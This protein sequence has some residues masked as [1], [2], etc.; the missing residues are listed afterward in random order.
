MKITKKITAIFCI[1]AILLILNH[2]IPVL[3]AS[4]DYVVKEL[5]FVNYLN[6]GAETVVADPTGK[7]LLFFGRND[8]VY[9]YNLEH[10]I[11]KKLIDLS[12]WNIYPFHALCFSFDGSMFAVACDE[13]QYIQLFDSKSGELLKEF[14]LP[15]DDYAAK[16]IYDIA[17]TTENNIIILGGNDTYI[18]ETSSKQ[19]LNGGNVEDFVLAKMV[20]STKSNGSVCQN[21]TN[22]DIAVYESYYNLNF[23]RIY[24]GKTGGNTKTIS[25]NDYYSNIAYSADGKYLALSNNSNSVI[26]DVTD[27]YNIVA[28]FAVGGKL[29]FS[30]DLLLIG[31]KVYNSSNN[32]KN[33]I[34]IIEKGDYYDDDDYYDYDNDYTD[35]LLT[36]DGKYF[37][38]YSNGVRIL[39]ASTISVYLKE[40][41]LDDNLYLQPN[42][43]MNLNL[44]G[45]NTDGSTVKLDISKAK[46]V[47]S[48]FT[49]AKM[50]GTALVGL[51]IGTAYIDITYEGLSLR[52]EITVVAEKPSSWAITDVNTAVDV[53]LVPPPLQSLYTQATTRS[54]FCVLAVALYETVTGAVIEERETFADTNDVNIEKAAAIKVVYGVGDNK[55]APD[56]PLTREQAATMLS[57]LADAV[58]RPLKKEASTFSDNELI[59]SWALEAVGQMQITGIMG[60]VGDNRFSPKSPYT[61]EQS[62]VTILRLYNVLTVDYENNKDTGSN[63][64]EPDPSAVEFLNMLISGNL[65][66]YMSNE[67]IGEV[68]LFMYENK[69]AMLITMEEMGPVRVIILKE[70]EEVYMVFEDYREYIKYDYIPDVL[71]ALNFDFS[72]MSD[73]EYAGSG[74]VEFDGSEIAYDAFTSDEEDTYT[75]IFVDA[76]KVVGIGT[77]DADGLATLTI[78]I[79]GYATLDEETIGNLFNVEYIETNYV[80]SE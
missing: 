23:L 24:N 34:V 31:N 12:K 28:E 48:D 46:C 1:V 55:F 8:G 61:R 60:G 2:M 36:P 70:N 42:Q 79:I 22:N 65:H 56:T 13:M 15:E 49:I 64:S 4:T 76:E 66:M 25:C 72:D 18:I 27:N 51:T 3:A 10:G 9:L 80:L 44:I 47:I 68:A 57:R 38:Y 7:L 5:P 75:L 20:S 21:P 54:E 41:R 40:L 78:V 58:K 62:I 37:I 50:E 32:F 77:L 6:I 14:S 59:S 33:G 63:D 11:N 53:G 45:V 26:Y 29:S 69:T 73:T 35:T 74:T 52:K 71:A 39:D 19:F 16:F 43:S 17:F 30:G 67:E